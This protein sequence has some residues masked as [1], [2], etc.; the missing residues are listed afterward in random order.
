MSQQAAEED[1]KKL[2]EDAKRGDS[3]SA[4][5]EAQQLQREFASIRFDGPS[6]PTLQPTIFPPH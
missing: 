3:D 2:V 4:H 1:I 5:A 6:M